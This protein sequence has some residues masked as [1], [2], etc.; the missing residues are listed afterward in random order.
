MIDQIFSNSL[1]GQFEY[2]Q[3]LGIIVKTAS[4]TE[5][6]RKIEKFAEGSVSCLIKDAA[7][8]RKMLHRERMSIH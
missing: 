5:R 7:I 3:A 2:S 8:N 6:H 4:I 1:I